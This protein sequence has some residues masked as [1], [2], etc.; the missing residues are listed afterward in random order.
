MLEY[1]PFIKKVLNRYQSVSDESVSLLLSISRIQN[2]KK[3]DL[4]LDIGKISKEKHIL[5]KGA[6]VSYFT[7]S[8]GELYHKNIFLEDD[9]VGST[10]SA[11]KEKPSEFALEAIEDTTLISFNHRK[12]HELI[13]RNSDLKNFYIAYL[14]KNWVIEKERREIDI[15]LKNANERYLDFIKSHA[16]IETRIPLHYI[17]S[18]LGITPTQLSRIRKKLKEK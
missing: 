10:V 18:H 8:R 11:L 15:I 17:A 2:L 3:G 7:N 4:L 14:E 5:Y 6:I 12:Y 13:S 9:F 16:K 1:K